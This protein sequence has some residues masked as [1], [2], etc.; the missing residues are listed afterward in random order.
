MLLKNYKVKN[1]YSASIEPHEVFLDN[2]EKDK[3][4]ESGFSEKRFEVDVRG[5]IISK[6]ILKLGEISTKNWSMPKNLIKKQKRYSNKEA[7]NK[8]MKLP[9]HVCLTAFRP[10]TDLYKNLQPLFDI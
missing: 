1:K 3:E 10:D 6:E 5:Q 8:K 4:A 2:L 7:N 9:N